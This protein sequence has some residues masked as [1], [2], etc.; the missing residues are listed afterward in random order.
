MCLFHLDYFITRKQVELTRSAPKAASLRLTSQ[1]AQQ[2]SRP[3]TQQDTA[4]VLMIV[5]K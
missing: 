4:L 1:A 5:N 3:P 2:P